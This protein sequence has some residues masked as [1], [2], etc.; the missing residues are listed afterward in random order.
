M[1]KFFSLIISTMMAFTLTA[2]GSGNA[3]DSSTTNDTK[4]G[5]VPSNKNLVVYFSCSGSTKILAQNTA[6]AINADIF[7]IKAKIPYTSA[8]LDWHNKNSRSSIEM[9]DESVRPEIADKISNFD[10]YK[11]IV[12]AY[13]IWWNQAPRIVDTFIESYDF[14]NKT[15]VPICTS[16]GSDIIA[17]ENFLKTLAPGAKWI[18]GKRFYTSTSVDEL[19][20]WFNDKL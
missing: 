7:E 12:I 4:T 19:K 2:C 16:G 5:S 10:Q 13:P 15:V 8:D 18:D 20:S 9:N 11:T 1:K 3:A 14:T 17:S 6:S